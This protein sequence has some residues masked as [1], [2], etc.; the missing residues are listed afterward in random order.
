MTDLQARIL[1]VLLL[2]LAERE[3][4]SGLLTLIVDLTARSEID[5]GAFMQKVQALGVR[6]TDA[7]TA[8]EQRL[9]D[10]LDDYRGAV[11]AREALAEV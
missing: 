4:E 3:Y 7:V 8:A 6:R 11:H 2:L 10:A 5:P 1:P 9:A